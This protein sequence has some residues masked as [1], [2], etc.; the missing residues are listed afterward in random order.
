MRVSAVVLAAGKSSRMGKNKLLLE[1]EGKTILDNLL[2]TLTLILKEVVVVTGYDPEPIRRIAEKYDCLLVHNFKHEKGMT[3]SFQAGLSAI[4]TDGVF[5]VLGDQ[6]GLEKG[7]LLKMIDKLSNEDALI[8]SPIHKGKYGHPVLFH[9]KIYTEILNQREDSVL[10]EI[11]TN[12]SNKHKTVK[13]SVWTTLDFDTP[14]D[15]EK[16]KKLWVKRDQV[17]A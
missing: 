5:L 15:F 2:S 10:K 1:I 6:I 7:L 17:T 11:I 9:R 4:N 13:G 8:I 16:I 3:S 14:E 12:N